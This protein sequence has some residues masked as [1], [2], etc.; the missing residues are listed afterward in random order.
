MQQRGVM[1]MKVANEKTVLRLLEKE[2]EKIKNL[3]DSLIEQKIKEVCILHDLDFNTLALK[4]MVRDIK[5]FGIPCIS[6]SFTNFLRLSKI[7]FIDKELRSF[8]EPYTPIQKRYNKLFD[9]SFSKRQ[10]GS[11]YDIFLKHSPSSV[12]EWEVLVKKNCGERIK[13]QCSKIFGSEYD[14]ISCFSNDL[15]K[16]RLKAEIRKYAERFIYVKTFFGFAFQVTTIKL[17]SKKLKVKTVFGS[18]EEDSR[19]IDAFANGVPYNV[20]PHSFHHSTG[21]RHFN[22]KIP[23]VI[24]HADKSKNK[25]VIDFSS[26]AKE[27]FK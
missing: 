9:T 25:V 20:K 27:I 2:N 5:K 3:K 10:I 13:E 1:I 14:Y 24:Y 17:V 18:D 12:E 26:L 15:N 8:L 11:L 23:V 22:K 4:K 21:E 19:F 16:R 7:T 6:M